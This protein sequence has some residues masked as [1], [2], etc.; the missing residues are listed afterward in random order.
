MKSLFVN[1]DE[2]KLEDC[3]LA[4]PCGNYVRPNIFSSIFIFQRNGEF[5]LK[6]HS[7]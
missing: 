4:M 2:L 5:S 6:N 3:M 1:K 7:L